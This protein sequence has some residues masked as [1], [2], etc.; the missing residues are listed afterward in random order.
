MNQLPFAGIFLCAVLR[1]PANGLYASVPTEIDFY[2]FAVSVTDYTHKDHECGGAIISDFHVLS[3]CQCFSAEENIQ[4]RKRVQEY[5]ICAL[6]KD[7][8]QNAVNFPILDIMLHP[9]CRARETIYD[10]N[11]AVVRVKDSFN[12]LK[13]VAP[14]NLPKKNTVDDL[15]TYIT[16]NMTFSVVGYGQNS[17]KADSNTTLTEA[18]VTLSSWEDCHQFFNLHNLDSSAK[19]KLCFNVLATNVSA[20]KNDDGDP[21]FIQSYLWGIISTSSYI[22]KCTKNQLTIVAR[23]DT[24]IEWVERCMNDGSSTITHI[25]VMYASILLSLNFLRINL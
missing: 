3:S 5:L 16:L 2:P 14:I 1:A 20:C 21:V 8:Y 25:L 9:E 15:Q 22:H 11:L 23:I 7:R 13:N 12:I 24:S 4:I 18:A 19:D 10:Y 17:A 6:C